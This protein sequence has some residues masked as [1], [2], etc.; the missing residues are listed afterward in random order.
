MNFQLDLLVEQISELIWR[1]NKP[2]IISLSFLWPISI[3]PSDIFLTSS[4]ARWEGEK[5]R[6]SHDGLFGQTIYYKMCHWFQFLN[7]DLVRGVERQKNTEW[8]VGHVVGGEKRRRDIPHSTH[9]IIPVCPSPHE[10]MWLIDPYDKWHKTHKNDSH[11]NSIKSSRT[12]GTRV[13]IY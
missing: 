6:N 2:N 5:G 8:L 12:C 4:I 7:P 9:T 10:S 3:Q 11:S 13:F 1:G